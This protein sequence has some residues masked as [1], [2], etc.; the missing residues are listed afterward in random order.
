MTD[1]RPTISKGHVEAALPAAALPPVQAANL[2][3]ATAAVAVPS[4]DGGRTRPGTVAKSPPPSR[5]QRQ[6]P[7]RRPR[8]ACLSPAGAKTATAAAVPPPD[9]AGARPPHGVDAA[10]ATSPPT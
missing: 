1:T 4:P 5:C 10:P 7:R 9:A 3:P 6:L 2:R 8:A